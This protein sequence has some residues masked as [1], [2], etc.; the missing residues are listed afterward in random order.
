MGGGHFA[1]VL[2]ICL[3]EK[4]SL[5]L[6][7]GKDNVLRMWDPRAPPHTC[8]VAALLEHTDVVSSV[9]A[10]AS[11]EHAYTASRDKTVKIWDLGM[12]RCINT[13][14]GHTGPALCMDSVGSGHPVTCGEDKTVRAWN[15]DRD[16]HLMFNRHVAPVDAVACLDQDRFVSGSQDGNICLWSKKSKKPIASASLKKEWVSS[17]AAIHNADIVFSGSVDGSLCAWRYGQVEGVLDAVSKIEVGGTINGIAA[18][19]RILA[20]AVGREHR[21]GR[22]FCNKL[23]KN[24]VVVVPFS[25][26]E[27]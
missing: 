6:S 25:Y 4:H 11:G 5:L 12:R 22:W 17:V 19:K 13:L 1:Y 10:D 9:A 16:T 21:L 15:V 24:G 3:V 23:G 14:F 27:E 26:C 7:V 2:G 20:C 18:G 8:C